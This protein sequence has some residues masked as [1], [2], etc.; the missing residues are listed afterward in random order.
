MLRVGSMIGFSV[1]LT[2]FVT[3]NAPAKAVSCTYETCMA[4]CQK[5][6]GGNKQGG[7][8]GWCDKTI[9]ERQQSG[10]CKAK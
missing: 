4:A 10:V 2:A 6:G 9:R 5:A 7:C 1:F 3:M 8:S